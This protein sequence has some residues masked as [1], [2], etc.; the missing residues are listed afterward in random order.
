MSWPARTAGHHQVGH[1]Q[2]DKPCPASQLAQGD[3]GVVADD[4]SRQGLQGRKLGDQVSG[5]VPSEPGVQVVGASRDQGAGLVDRLGLLG[6]GAEQPA[7]RIKGG[8]DVGIS[9]SIYA[10]DPRAGATGPGRVGGCSS[11]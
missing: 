4:S 2:R 11:V 8:G 6:A 7:D 10:A 1:R 9:M 3:P 5:G